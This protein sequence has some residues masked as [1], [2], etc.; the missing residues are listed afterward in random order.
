MEWIV[1]QKVQSSQRDICSLQF[2]LPEKFRKKAM[3]A[4]HNDAGHF[5]LERSLNL[6]KD[7]FY[8][9]NMATGVERHI[10]KCDG[11]LRFKAQPQRVK[12]HL[13]QAT[14]PMEVIHVDF[15]TIE[16]G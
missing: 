16:L 10:K 1:V 3:E 8:L 12:L 5:G 14:L 6:L 4:C 11:C 7:R 13:L 2:V 15:L 9:P